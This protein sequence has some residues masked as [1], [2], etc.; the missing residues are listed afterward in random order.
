MVGEQPT[1]VPVVIGVNWYSAFDHPQQDSRGLWWI[2]RDGNLGT[3]RGGHC[4]CLRPAGVPDYTSWWRAYDQGR[5]GACVGFGCSRMS[6]LTNR[7]LYDA[8]WLYHEARKVDEWPGEDYDGTSVRAGLDV[9]RTVGHRRV[10]RGK[11]G[12]AD[13]TEGISAN[14][15]A[16]SVDDVMRALGREGDDAAPLLNSWGKDGYPHSVWV[17][18]S[19]LERLL[20]E[21]GEFGIPTDR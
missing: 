17:P 20:A 2:A 10:L 3:I 12:P 16:T 8:A 15:W 9:L 13:F 11:T 19:V 7:R 14:R 4:V 1:Y 21:D 18:V 5:E 6:S